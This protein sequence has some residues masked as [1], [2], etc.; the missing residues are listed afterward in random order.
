MEPQMSNHHSKTST[1]KIFIDGCSGG[2]CGGQGDIHR[3]NLN[4]DRKANQLVINKIKA[5][6]LTHIASIHLKKKELDEVMTS[7]CEAYTI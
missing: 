5:S 4:I 2:G 1:T 6:M 3:V 7:Y